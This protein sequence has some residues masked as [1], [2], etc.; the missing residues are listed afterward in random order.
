MNRNDIRFVSGGVCA[1]AGFTAGAVL[2][3]IKEN[4][5]GF[6]TA[7]IFSDDVCN[8]AGLFTKNRVKAAPVSL[9]AQKLQKGIAQ[10]IIVNSG[11][12]NA[13]TGLEG[14]QNAKRMTRETA[15]ALH[16][17]ESLVLVASTGVIGVQLPIEKISD[18]IAELAESLSKKNHENARCAI[19]T[20]DTQYKEYA[21]EFLLHGKKIRI[22]AMCKGSGMIHI[23]IGTMLAFITTDCAITSEL[24]KSALLESAAASYNCVSV[25]GDT[26]TNDSV[27]ILANGK[28]ENEII[29]KKNEEYEIFVT[30]LTALNIVMA[31][32]IASDGEGATR[33]IECKISGA[34]DSANARKAA[35]SVISSNLVKA[36]FFG[37]DANWGRI[38]CALGYSG[39]NFTAEKTSI[40]FASDKNAKRFFDGDEELLLQKTIAEN[41]SC[42]NSDKKN[43]IDTK[44]KNKNEVE[45]ISVFENGVPLHFDESR[46]KQILES[47]C[48]SIE[49]KMQDGNAT[50]FAWGCDLTYDYVKINGDYRT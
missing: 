24:L 35:K 17:D 5:K 41:L 37:K 15:A 12:A 14:I 11:N 21:V 28:A 2:C 9:S 20:T 19:M 8:A 13:C 31:K 3:R 36:A 50:G 23:N 44:Q 39:A 6:D 33:L 27:F 16:I 34:C 47:E 49:V 38:L 32:K 22:G 26:S 10:A 45:R 25:D 48:V 1:P 29:A 30:A 43:S 4:R 18:H 46:A 42:E 7:L 40:V